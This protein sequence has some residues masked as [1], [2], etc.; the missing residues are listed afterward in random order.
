MEAFD[1]FGDEDRAWRVLRRKIERRVNR[2]T[3]IDLDN[4]SPLIY[5]IIQMMSDGGCENFI[6]KITSVII[7]WEHIFL[8]AE[9]NSLTGVKSFFFKRFN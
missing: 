3:R 9:S 5:Y 7:K 4:N 6:D 8:D 1:P 2:I